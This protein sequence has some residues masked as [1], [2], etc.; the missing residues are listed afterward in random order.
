MD[1]QPRHQHRS[2]SAAS[3]RTIAR[4]PPKPLEARRARRQ[5]RLKAS[6]HEYIQRKHLRTDDPPIIIVGGRT[7][8]LHQQHLNRRRSRGIAPSQRHGPRPRG[9]RADQTSTEEAAPS[10]NILATGQRFGRKIEGRLSAVRLFGEF[11]GC[12]RHSF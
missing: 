7:P 12:L 10:Q 6:S 5:R 2:P 11:K 1:D 4:R 3:H 8:Q 9:W